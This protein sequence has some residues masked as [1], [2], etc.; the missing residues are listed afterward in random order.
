MAQKSIADRMKPS[1]GPPTYPCTAI[2]SNETPADWGVNIIAIG[3]DFFYEDGSSAQ[4]GPLAI[5]IPG[6]SGNASLSSP[7]PLKCCVKVV[8]AVTVKA[9]NENPQSFSKTNDAPADQCWLQ[10]HFI[11]APQKSISSKVHSSGIKT[12]DALTLTDKR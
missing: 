7:N 3:A 2:F 1:D 5:T 4:V 10:T 12:A 6:P 8:G 11:L 9:Q